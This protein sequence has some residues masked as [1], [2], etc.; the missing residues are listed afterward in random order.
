MFGRG[1][2]MIVKFEDYAKMTFGKRWADVDDALDNLADEIR[3]T[4]WQMADSGKLWR[5]FAEMENAVERYRDLLK[6]ETREYFKMFE[7][8]DYSTKK[9]FELEHENDTLKKQLTERNCGETAEVTVEG[10]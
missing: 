1:G 8:Q 7:A 6:D 4:E 2:V 10:R 9:I 5:A 3:E